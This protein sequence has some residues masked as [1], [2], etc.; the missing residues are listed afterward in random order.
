M[1]SGSVDVIFLHKKG[2]PHA[3][4]QVPETHHLLHVCDFFVAGN[5]EAQVEFGGWMIP[6]TR[7]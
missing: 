6:S 2:N 3:P 5:K 4:M 7:W 1:K